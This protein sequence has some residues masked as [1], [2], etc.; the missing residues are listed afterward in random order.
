MK[1]LLLVLCIAFGGNVYGQL[2]GLDG[3]LKEA[4]QNEERIFK[5][6][7]EAFFESTQ[8]LNDHMAER[9]K[10]YDYESTVILLMLKYQVEQVKSEM[11]RLSDFEFMFSA[12]ARGASIKCP[13]FKTILSQKLIM[14]KR[15]KDL[16]KK[17][18]NLLEEAKRHEGRFTATYAQNILNIKRDSRKLMRKCSKLL[19]EA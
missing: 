18:E 10:D 11:S 3:G 16:Y 1:K 19:K 17:T 13:Q 8:N 9:I 15:I 14:R 5:Y 4:A 12:I 7:S 6:E 2:D